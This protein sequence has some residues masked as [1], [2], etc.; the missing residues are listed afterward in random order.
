MDRTTGDFERI[1]LPHLDAAYNLA[2]WLTH[3]DQDARDVVQESFLRAFKAFDQFHGPVNDA[4]CWLL[5]IVRNTCFTW[6]RRN[7]S[8]HATMSLDI[9]AHAPKATEADPHANMEMKD[10]RDAIRRAIE[11][12]PVEFREAIILREFENLSYRQISAIAN[13]PVGTIMSRLARARDRLHKALC[14]RMIEEA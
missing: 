2:H 1:V 13:V 14:A 7:R 6:L 10:D 8:S 11:A 4:R 12:L 9:D 3:R 5:A